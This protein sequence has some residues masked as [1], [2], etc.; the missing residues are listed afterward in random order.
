LQKVTY[1][2]TTKIGG[3]MTEKDKLREFILKELA[4]DQSLD[5]LNDDYPLLDNGIVDSM[6]MLKLLEFIE[7][8]FAIVLSDEDL[9]AENF[10]SIDTMA[11]LIEKRKIAA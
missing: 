11:E 10:E 9:I 8:K 5:E 1:Q 6:G 7:G 3:K 2:T 4:W